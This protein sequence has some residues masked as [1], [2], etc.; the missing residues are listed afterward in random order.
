[1]LSQAVKQATNQSAE[2]LDH[3][4]HVADS[5][6]FVPVIVWQVS[7]ILNHSYAIEEVCSRHS[8]WVTPTASHS[9]VSRSDFDG[10]LHSNIM[11]SARVRSQKC[12]M[13]HRDLAAVL[14]SQICEYP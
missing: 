14:G 13:S 4:L 6:L 1:M 12:D 3:F 2:G 8:E 5:Q 9:E 7:V 11:R 10:V